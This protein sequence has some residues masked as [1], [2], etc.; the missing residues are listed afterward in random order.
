[1]AHLGGHAGARIEEGVG[2]TS[3]LCLD[4]IREL[5]GEQRKLEAGEIERVGRIAGHRAAAEER[6]DIELVTISIV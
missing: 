2:K 4:V 3:E 1:M 5:G 6:S